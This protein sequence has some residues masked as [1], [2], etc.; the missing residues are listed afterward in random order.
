VIFS[1][2]QPYVGVPAY[3]ID[4]LHEKGVIASNKDQTFV[5]ADCDATLKMEFKFSDY[6]VVVSKKDIQYKFGSDV[7]TVFIFPTFENVITLGIMSFK[8]F[9]HLFNYED[10]TMSLATIKP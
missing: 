1:P 2:E 9:C 8:Q 4:F 10:N 7:C 6:P 5:T 3:I